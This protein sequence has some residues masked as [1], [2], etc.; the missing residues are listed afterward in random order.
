M[1]YLDCFWIMGG[2]LLASVL[3]IFFMQKPRPGAAPGA[4]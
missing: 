4:H 3:A 1:A 2:V